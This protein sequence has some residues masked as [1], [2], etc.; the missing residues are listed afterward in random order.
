MRRYEPYDW[1]M[2]YFIGKYRLQLGER[3]FWECTPRKF[4]KLHDLLNGK[5]ESR[6][7]LPT[8][9]DLGI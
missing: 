6:N 1:D 7:Q 5:V 4:W 9:A 3:E 8:L 2:L